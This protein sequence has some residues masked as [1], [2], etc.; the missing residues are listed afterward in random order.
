MVA[1]SQFASDLDESTKRRLTRGKRI[2]ESMKQAQNSPYK[3]W[4]EVVIIWAVT[5]GHFDSIAENDVV[6]KI[7][8]LLAH[9]EGNMSNLI[10]MIM[11]KKELTDEIK[12]G[13]DDVM[14]DFFSA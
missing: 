12:Q 6:L 3:L 11:D 8:Q 9:T 7:K 4:E 5:N 10:T 2:V 14:K 1:F 13:L